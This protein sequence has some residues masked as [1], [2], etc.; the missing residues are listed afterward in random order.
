MWRN[1]RRTRFRCVR[2]NSWGFESL[3]RQIKKKKNQRS[4]SSPL[5]FFEQRWFT[6]RASC[7]VRLILRQRC[8]QTLSSA[9]F[10]KNYVCDNIVFVENLILM[11]TWRN[12]YTRTF[13]GRVGKPVRVQVPPSTN[14]KDYNFC[15]GLFYY[16]MVLTRNAK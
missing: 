16:M 12:R 7:P 4:D 3:H 9:N 5:L 10:Y 1:G 14:K 13:E 2:G 11:S 6:L 8:K 15:Y